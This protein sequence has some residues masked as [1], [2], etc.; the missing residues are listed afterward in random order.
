MWL[1]RRGPIGRID[2]HRGRLLFSLVRL[3]PS[4]AHPLSSSEIGTKMLGNS[5]RRRIS[6]D[7]DTVYDGVVGGS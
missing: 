2:C 5:Y 4:T 6:V 7:G 1:Y 3:R